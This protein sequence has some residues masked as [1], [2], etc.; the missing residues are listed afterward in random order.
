MSSSFNEKFYGRFRQRNEV[1]SETVKRVDTEI[2]N[3]NFDWMCERDT[4]QSDM[5]IN[6]ERNSES[7]TQYQKLLNA[8]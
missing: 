2:F 5:I 3:S 1:M 6:T 4:L 8:L 7:C